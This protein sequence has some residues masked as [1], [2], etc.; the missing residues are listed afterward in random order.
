M[1]KDSQRETAIEWMAGGR[2]GDGH[3][4]G[5]QHNNRRAPLN[6]VGLPYLEAHTRTQQPYPQ[7]SAFNE[8]M[9]SAEAFLPLISRERC[10]YVANNRRVQ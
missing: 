7:R 4:R 1:P 8:G 6:L 2:G 3:F 5:T 10:L 9:Q